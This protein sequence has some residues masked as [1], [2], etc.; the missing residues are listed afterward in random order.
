[1]LY[2]Y[3]HCVCHCVCHSVICCR[4]PYSCSCCTV[5][6]IMYATVLSVAACRTVA[7][8]AQLLPLCIPVFRVATCRS[9]VYSCCHCVCH[10]VMCCR[11][12]C[13]CFMLYNDVI[14]CAS[15]LCYHMLYSCVRLLLLCMPQC[16]VL[17]HTVQLLHVVQLLLFCV[18]VFCVA[19]CCTVAH[20]VQLLLLYMPQCCVSASHT[21]LH[22]VQLLPLCI[23]VFC[24]A[25]C[26]TVFFMLYSHCQFIC[27][28]SSLSCAVQLLLLHMPQCYVS[29]PPCCCMPCSSFMLYSSS[30]SAACRTVAAIVHANVLG[31]RMSY[32]CSCCTV[33]AAVYATVLCV[34]A[35]T[36]YATQ[37]YVLS[38]AVVVQ[39]L[40][41]CMPGFCVAMCRCPCCT[42]AATV[43]AT[44]LGMCLLC[45]IQLLRLY[46]CC[47]CVCQ[48]FFSLHAVQSLL[49]KVT[50][51]FMHCCTLSS[52]LVATP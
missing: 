20:V 39:W 37:C 6:A 8:V 25:T 18:L 51:L 5:A 23:P 34:V 49:S 11:L 46:S 26:H 4:M 10:S 24:I 43:Y 9:V 22:V 31:C 14:L 32:S 48:Y 1:M 29:P 12:P 42:V 52:T 30:H 28:H 41:F 16:Y 27:Q 50:V 7:H 21:V 47:H 36:V 13:S 40:P 17:M 35:A 38:Y 3:C 33:T 45:A 44:V 19:T 2:S 15:V